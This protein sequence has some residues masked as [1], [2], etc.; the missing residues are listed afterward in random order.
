MAESTNFDSVF[1]NVTSKSFDG[2]SEITEDEF[3]KLLD[4]Q[5]GKA[6]GKVGDKQIDKNTK[7]EIGKDGKITAGTGAKAVTAYEL[8]SLLGP[9]SITHTVHLQPE[10]NSKDHFQSLV[11]GALNNAKVTGAGDTRKVTGLS[12][13]IDD[14]KITAEVKKAVDTPEEAA[15]DILKSGSAISYVEK[16]IGAGGLSDDET[17]KLLD[18]LVAESKKQIDEEENPTKKKELQQKYDFILNAAKQAAHNRGIDYADNIT[19]KDLSGKVSQDTLD[20]ES[21][22]AIDDPSQAAK[23]ILKS[24]SAV[25]YIEH[26]ISKGGLSDDQTKA[27][28][29]ALETEINEQLDAETDETKQKALQQKY[30]VIMEAA[31]KAALG[32]GVNY[33]GAGSDDIVKAAKEKIKDGKY[34]E[35]VDAIEGT[36]EKSNS[37]E[38]REWALYKLGQDIDNDTH[39]SDEQKSN[40]KKALW[41]E[42]QKRAEGVAT[43]NRITLAG[44]AEGLLKGWSTPSSDDSAGNNSGNSGSSWGRDNSNNGNRQNNYNDGNSDWSNEDNKGSGWGSGSNNYNGDNRGGYGKEYG[45]YSGGGNDYH[46]SIVGAMQHGD[47]DAAVMLILSDDAPEGELSDVVAHAARGQLSPQQQQEFM[48]ALGKAAFGANAQNTTKSF[49]SA[50]NSGHG[51]VSPDLEKQLTKV[52]Y[53][54]GMFQALG[55]NPP[56]TLTQIAEGQQQQSS[57]PPRYS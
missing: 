40:K 38:N 17:T 52:A 21:Q 57:L 20:K 26:I 32:R 46:N 42:L 15:K 13:N 44:K 19:A 34:K 22:T 37:I 31:K 36:K 53:A 51:H 56:W 55:G 27:L 35:A 8:F 43:R 3:L 4:A 18:A 49:L 33:E 14:S 39:L 28:L 7:L 23:D 54:Q 16:I 12:G 29:D 10:S 50:A 48:D 2:G 1:K 24:G 5:D 25:T 6:D 41:D 47:Y 9:N 11:S 30:N 45:G